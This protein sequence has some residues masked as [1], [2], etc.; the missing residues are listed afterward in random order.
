MLNLI[1]GLRHIHCSVPHELIQVLCSKMLCVCVCVC[2]CVCLCV[3]VCVCL[4]VCVCVC[5]CVCGGEMRG[6]TVD[7][8]VVECALKVDGIQ[9]GSSQWGVEQRFVYTQTHTHKH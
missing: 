8:V 4:C 6:A 2:V 3:C 9:G 5:V 7:R 1:K